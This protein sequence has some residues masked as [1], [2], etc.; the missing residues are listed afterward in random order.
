[1]PSIAEVR[2]PW[3]RT[4]PGAVANIVF[5]YWRKH[6][7][8]PRLFAP[9][10]YTEKIQWRKLF[11]LDPLHTTLC[12]KLAVRDWVA[13]RAGEHLLLPLLWSGD[14]PGD[15]P[16][17]EFRRPYVVKT[18]HS[19]ATNIFV[20]DPAALDR[21]QARAALRR[22]LARNHGIGLN[23]SGH[24]G[25]NPRVMVEP[26]VTL[27][28]GAPPVDYKFFVFAGR[29]QLIAV[30]INEDHLLHST[31]HLRP[32]WSATP[33]KLDTPLYAGPP[34]RAP[35]DL[36]AMIAAAETIAAG[37]DHLRVDF[38]HDGD[39]F[40]L[41]EVSLY[42]QSGMVPMTPDEMDGWLGSLW[43]LPNPGKRALAALRGS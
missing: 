33:L 40:W 5:R 8:L 14:D 13:A 30:R 32:D 25:V 34:L 19:N 1:V 39:R 7:R 24:V 2:R 17:D 37:L 28:D 35:R 38:L 26:M 3:K 9:R 42:S 23:E 15:I 10:R 43:P 27:V 11:D 18:N 21:D 4:P 29:V 36:A 20:D 6:R 31:L 16:F 22:W 41:G 12:D